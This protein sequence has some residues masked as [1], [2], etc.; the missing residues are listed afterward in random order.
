MIE[1]NYITF[2]ELGSFKPEEF[3]VDLREVAAIS[4]YDSTTT[5]LYFNGDYKS[6]SIA[7]NEFDE[8]KIAWRSA[9]NR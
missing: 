4:Q 2:A 5:K 1:G 8:I 6:V 9:N 3:T 7:D